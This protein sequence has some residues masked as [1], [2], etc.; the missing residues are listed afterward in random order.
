MIRKVFSIICHVIAGFFVY[1][2]C[3]IAFFKSPS[4][5]AKLGIMGGC[6]LA[7]LV[8]LAVGLIASGGWKW[9]RDIGIVLVSGS[10][11]TA[12]L[13]LIMLCLSLDPGFKEFFP[14][15]EL[16][17]FKDYT[18]G[19]ICI[20]TCAASG[21]VLIRASIRNSKVPPPQGVT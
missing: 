3:L 14:N 17:A 10:G 11:F 16:D 9:Q 2:L 15:A 7:A 5:G 12:L 18:V 13:C 19:L 20:G 21:I 8:P 4:A 6:I 1:L